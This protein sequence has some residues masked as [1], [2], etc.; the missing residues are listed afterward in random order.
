MAAE[1]KFLSFPTTPY[2]HLP[3]LSIPSRHLETLSSSDFHSPPHRRDCH[4]KPDLQT[5]LC[6]PHCS[7]SHAWPDSHT[8]LLQP[9]FLNLL[10]SLSLRC[11]L[12]A[13][14]VGLVF[15]PTY[16]RLLPARALMQRQVATGD[17]A[18][19]DFGAQRLTHEQILTWTLSLG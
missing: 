3:S 12:A 14:P 10:L 18:S 15:R 13:T 11:C 17:G 16:L 1:R 9:R 7:C 5:F 2:P 19:S 6:R 8:N 4:A